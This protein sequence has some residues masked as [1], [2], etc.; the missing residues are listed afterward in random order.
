[1]LKITIETKVVSS[2]QLFSQLSSKTIVDKYKTLIHTT[3]LPIKK[4]NKKQLLFLISLYKKTL[5]ER[6][7]R[8]V[9]RCN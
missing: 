1:M 4:L 7:N 8:I 5:D 3:K 2:L 9:D 6:E